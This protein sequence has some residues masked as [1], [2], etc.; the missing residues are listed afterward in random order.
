MKNNRSG[1]TLFPIVIGIFISLLVIGVF[2]KKTMSDATE[3]KKELRL[4]AT[5]MS[6]YGFQSV[7][8]QIIA[9]ENIANDSFVS[10]D[11][12]TVGDG[13]YKINVQKTKK[14]DTMLVTIESIG[15]AGDEIV[16]QQKVF[17]LLEIEND[18]GMCWTALPR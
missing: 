9:I 12:T 7:T 11:S 15:G 13:W 14:N 17:K 8:E 4:V 16:S 5:Q 6:D 10:V 3:A 1:L 18:T 2:M